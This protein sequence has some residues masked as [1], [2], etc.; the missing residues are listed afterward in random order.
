MRR[1]NFCPVKS[2]R[3]LLI[4]SFLLGL[5]PGLYTPTALGVT[6]DE[7]QGKDSFLFSAIALAQ[8][9]CTS[10]LIII[11]P[12]DNREASEFL[13]CKV[14]KVC[15]A[16]TAL[17]VTSD[18]IRGKDSFLFSA[19]ALAQPAGTAFLI[20]ISPRDNREASE[21]LPCKVLKVC[22]APTAF[23]V[24]ADEILGKN[25]LLLTTHTL[26]QPFCISR[27]IIVSPGDNCEASE[28]LPSQVPEVVPELC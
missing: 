24:T 9:L 4:S 7:I 5:R 12:R 27:A 11:S 13:P 10:F 23:S 28:L 18:E 20:I 15:L 3:W 8:P 17:G 16:P 19:I 25:S 22:L 26:A 6:A 14:L 2:I 21:F 1:P